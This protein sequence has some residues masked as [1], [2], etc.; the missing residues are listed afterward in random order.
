[1]VCCLLS[2]AAIANRRVTV[3]PYMHQVRTLVRCE[4]GSVTHSQRFRSNPG[5]TAEESSTMSPF[6][7]I[8]DNHDSLQRATIHDT[9]AILHGTRV[10]CPYYRRRRTTC[11][12]GTTCSWS[13]RSDLK[14]DQQL[15]NSRNRDAS[16]LRLGGLMLR[17]DRACDQAHSVVQLDVNFINVNGIWLDRSAIFGRRVNKRY[18]GTQTTKTDF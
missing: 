14:Y 12:G 18:T 4:I 8:F 7:V 3:A 11:V 6:T 2:E 17:F 10:N 16:R 5:G 9:V 1:M 15:S 13:N